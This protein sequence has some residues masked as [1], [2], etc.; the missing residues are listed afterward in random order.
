MNWETKLNGISFISLKNKDGESHQYI[1]LSDAHKIGT[2][3]FNEAL[4]K[5]KEIYKEEKDIVD[6]LNDM[7]L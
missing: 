3:A 2:F 5:I 4:D 1:K 6:I 7:K